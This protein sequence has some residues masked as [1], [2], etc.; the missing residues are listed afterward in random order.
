M[1]LINQIKTF[2]YKKQEKS[3]YK[4]IISPCGTHI[5]VHKKK[6]TDICHIYKLRKKFKTDELY[7]KSKIN[8]SPSDLDKLMGFLRNSK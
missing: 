6:E 7:Y 8:I 3:T 4:I 2:F 1:K 5:F